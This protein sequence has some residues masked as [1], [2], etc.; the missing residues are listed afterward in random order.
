MNCVNWTGAN[1]YITWLSGLTG[2]K[3]ALPST[4]QWEYAV[5]TS[6][7][8]NINPWTY[9]FSQK[10]STIKATHEDEEASK[11]LLLIL[12]GSTKNMWEW[13]SDLKPGTNNSSVAS[14]L[15][16]NR[17]LRGGEWLFIGWYLDERV[18]YWNYDSLNH[19]NVIFRPVQL[20]E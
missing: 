2:R 18:N 9:Y 12:G 3:Y 14:T 7:M 20:L 6:K 1:E 17:I 4:A 16:D 15:S 13:C 8:V 19:I 11:T 5:K 10:I